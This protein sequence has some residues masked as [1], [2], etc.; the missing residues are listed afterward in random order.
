MKIK[1]IVA[2]YFSPT[3][4]T[5]QLAK[6]MAGAVA[7]EAAACS[8]AGAAGTAVP[9]EYLDFTRPDARAGQYSFA[10]DDL[11]IIGL[12]V[13]AGRLP[14]KIL[15]FVQENL[16]GDGTPSLAFV[17]Y[18]NRAF[19]D[20][21]SELVYEQKNTGFRPAAAAA[22]AT[23]HAFASALAAGRPNAADLEEAKAF[24]RDV[25]A[26]IARS[27]D[28]E[29]DGNHAELQVDGNTPPGPY[30]RP[31]R[32]DGEP[33]VF[34]KAKP[35]TDTDKC[36]SCGTCARVCSM[37]SID[38]SDVINVPGICIK[39]QACVTHCPMGAKYFDDP[40]FLSHKEMLEANFREEKKNRFWI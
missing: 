39:C 6:A 21:L 14:N 37:G 18:G 32:M 13:Y 4:N 20:G 24:S 17:C 10:A 19:D 1:R 7:E 31:K 15:P 11:L 25:W 27:G 5:E 9:V 35:L 12:P 36:V 22:F 26:K 38:P 30:Y 29:G 2:A 33:A 16:K 40:D 34:L 28:D 23:Q 3:G 8:A